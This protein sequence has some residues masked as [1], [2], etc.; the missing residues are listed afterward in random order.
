MTEPV[1]HHEI[2]GCVLPC[3]ACRR[4]CQEHDVAEPHALAVHGCAGFVDVDPTDEERAMAHHAV[5]VVRE[6][7]GWAVVLAPRYDPGNFIVPCR[8]SK[9]EEAELVADG[10]RLVIAEVLAETRICGYRDS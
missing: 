5:R 7:N 2:R 1:C 4:E 6:S 10:I 3:G 8:E 9:Q